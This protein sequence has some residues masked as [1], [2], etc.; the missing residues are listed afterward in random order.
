[1]PEWSTRLDGWEDRIVAG[2]SLLPCGPLFPDEADKA[3]EI[4]IGLQ[5]VDVPGS[6]RIGDAC[7]PWMRDFARV[8]FG[9]CDPETGR[10][11]IR[12]YLLT[13]AKKNGKSS[14]AAAIM[15][16][17]L[18]RNWRRSAEF[19]ILAPTVEVAANSFNPARDMVRADPALMDLLRI[20]D[21]FRT[22][23][24]R[25]T[26]ATLKVVAADNE[27]VSGKKAAG[28][29]IDELWLFGKR[30]NAEN[31]LREAIGG[32]A[33]RPE[34]FVIYLSTQS[35]TPPAGVFKQKLQEFRDIRDGK[36]IDPKSLGVLYE[37][38]RRMIDSGEYR[39]PKNFYIT[40]PS[41]GTSVDHE[42]LFDEFTKAERAGEGSLA[43]FVAKHLNV[44]LGL[45]LGSDAW[46]GADYWEEQADPSLTIEAVIERSDVICVGIDGGGLDDLMALAVLGRGAATRDWLLVNKTWAHPIVL[47]RRKGEAS[48]LL[49]FA[50]A[51]ELVIVGR[52]G[53]DVAE[54]AELCAKLDASGKLAQIGLDPMGVGSVLD[55]LEERGLS[56]ERVVAVSQGWRLAGAIKTAE[57]KLAEGTLW[58][59]G[60]QIV[61]WAVGN[62]KVEPRGNA[63]TITK[64]TA[65]SAKIDP[66]M[67]AFDAVSLM[68]N[69][70]TAV[71]KPEYRLYFIGGRRR[72]NA[73][74]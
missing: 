68:S 17:S 26:G 43:S 13:V 27:T 29:L 61:S 69:N 35:D 22:I 55:A 45:A 16:T 2:Q 33:S 64:A 50:A 9:S 30:A 11:L 32:L 60:Q 5:L 46:A 66:L 74:F 37:F 62:A 58:H 52:I 20:Q 14:L 38:P 40:N 6:P 44:E 72:P 36:V 19:L 7:K 65:G 25:N 12:Y 28:V 49:D 63:I 56:G 47:E 18:I 23:T 15:L 4:F 42:F 31:M 67:A 41:L 39:D 1:M 24:H 48:R 57:R 51:G 73:A 3:M 8:V 54:I 71:K 34:G 21:N 53:Q 10:R 59:A 70:P